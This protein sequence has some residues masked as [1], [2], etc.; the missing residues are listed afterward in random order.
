MTPE[1]R[2]RKAL[3][4]RKVRDP[5]SWVDI[6][7]SVAV[8]IRAAENDALEGFAKFLLEHRPSAAQIKI[9]PEYNEAVLA[10]FGWAANEAR[11]RIQ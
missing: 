2:A 7:Q 4:I 3:A 1:N 5:V 6:E 9:S 11:K 8:E 10:A